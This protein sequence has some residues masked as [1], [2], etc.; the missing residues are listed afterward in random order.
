MIAKIVAYRVST[1]ADRNAA[2][3]LM[4]RFSG[5]MKLPRRVRSGV[6]LFAS[7]HAGHNDREKTDPDHDTN[8]LKHEMPRRL[9]PFQLVVRSRTGVRSPG[10]KFRSSFRSALT[11]SPPVLTFGA[12][13][14]EPPPQLGKTGRREGRLLHFKNKPGR[15]RS[16]LICGAVGHG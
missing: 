15:Y 16:P 2:A 11:G 14:R 5:M 13:R 10:G 8:N 4:L 1:H 7:N 9:M 6:D 3:I 12:G